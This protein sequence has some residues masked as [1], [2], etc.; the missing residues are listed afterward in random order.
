MNISPPVAGKWTEVLVSAP[1]LYEIIAVENE[2]PAEHA[3][4]G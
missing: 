2:P 4:I 3:L 1:Q